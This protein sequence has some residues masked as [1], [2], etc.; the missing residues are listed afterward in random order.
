MQIIKK[1]SI[2]GG[3][4]FGLEVAGYISDINK[5]TSIRLNLWDDVPI[6][7]GECLGLTYQGTISDIVLQKD[8]IPLVCIGD[9]D[10][11]A[12]IG[13]L[14]RD[15]GIELGTFIHPA[16]T[17]SSQAHIASGC[18]VLPFSCISFSAKLGWNA[19]IN[20]HVGVGHHA[21]IGEHCVISPQ[22]LIAG[23]AKIGN[24]V[25]MGPSAVV[26]PGKSVGDNSKISAG[27]VVYRNY[28]NGAFLSG[29]PAKNYKK[30]DGHG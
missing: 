23:Y 19:F 12:R 20:S 5:G 30:G 10:T 7:T 25:F 24:K 26:T 6:N 21:V 11:R 13:L 14:L 27:S 4:G 15:K 29:N 2:I 3:G 9:C 8:E 28:P 1:Y 16:A 17:M 22:S 18:I